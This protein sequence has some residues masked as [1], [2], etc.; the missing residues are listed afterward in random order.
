MPKEWRR[1][2]RSGKAALDLNVRSTGEERASPWCEEYQEERFIVTRAAPWKS[3]PH[4]NAGNTVEERRFSAASG[5]NK[6]GAL[7]PVGI[8]CR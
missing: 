2:K 1:G 5:R 7:A 4:R 3:G 8:R 6:L